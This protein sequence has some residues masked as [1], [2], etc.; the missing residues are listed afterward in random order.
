MAELLYYTR[1]CPVP[2]RSLSPSSGPRDQ[3]QMTIPL[4]RGASR[5]LVAVAPQD[6]RGVSATF[7]STKLLG[8]IVIP[9]GGHRQRVTELYDARN[10]RGR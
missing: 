10:Y 4:V 3:F 2:I 7:D 9:V 5:V 8:S 6:A 1:P